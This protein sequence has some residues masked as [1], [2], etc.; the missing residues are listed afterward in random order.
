MEFFGLCLQSL[1]I[2]RF[3]IGAGWETIVNRRTNASLGT[4]SVVNYVKVEGFPVAQNTPG[5]LRQLVGERGRKLV[6]MKAGRSLLQPGTEA[7]PLPVLLAYQDDVRRL[8]EKR[9]KVLAAAL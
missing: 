4:T 7:E 6:A 3:V 9:S 1:D 5:D 2:S 8:D